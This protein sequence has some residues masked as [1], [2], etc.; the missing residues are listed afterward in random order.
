MEFMSLRRVIAGMAV[1]AALGLLAVLVWP[2][3]AR[4]SPSVLNLKRVEPAGILDEDGS[5]M[6][7]ASLSISN[8]E[9]SLRSPENYLYVKDIEARVGN[10]WIGVEG[11]FPR[12]LAPGQE[13]EYLVLISAHSDPGKVRFKYTGASIAL[14][15]F[16][17]PLR[18]LAERL[19][20]LVR[21]RLPHKIWQ[22]LGFNNYEP[23]SDWRQISVE[24]SRPATTD[25]GTQAAN[26]DSRTDT[27]PPSRCP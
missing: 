8:S 19:P 15:S 2:A 26:S 4:R 20:K 24:L 13:D 25:V 12:P 5:E 10:R 21:F 27:E 6:W 14:R 1:F 9:N 16:K 18:W 11:P 23:S 22:W 17:G 7:F 3:H